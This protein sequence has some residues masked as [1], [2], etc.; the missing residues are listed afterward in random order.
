MC[1]GEQLSKI[2]N[3]VSNAAKEIFKENLREV[4]LFGSYARGDF[5][6]ESDIDVL[7]VAD[8]DDSTLC[9]YRGKIDL[10]CSELLYDFGV[11]VSIVEKDY[12]TY[13]RF[14]NVL[15]FYQNIKKEGVKIA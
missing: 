5:D 4:V 11:V 10:L 3:I 2:L 14:A 6:E 1:T 12:E 9:E 7:I 15:P 13:N 8:M